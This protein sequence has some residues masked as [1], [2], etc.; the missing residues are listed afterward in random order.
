MS[1]SDRKARSWALCERLW[2][3]SPRPDDRYRATIEPRLRP[4]L[5]VLDAGCGRHL[6]WA[7]RF[8]EA[9]AEVVGCDVDPPVGDEPNHPAALRR[10]MRS[11]GLAERERCAFGQYPA[12]LMFSPTLFRLGTWYERALDRCSCLE[13]L[14]G[15]L[16][17]VYEKQAG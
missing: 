10:Q 8:A 5:R 6:A 4:G 7:R 1:L 13:A 3:G 12:Y 9:G 11:A 17:G 2:N 16:I 14:R 15:W